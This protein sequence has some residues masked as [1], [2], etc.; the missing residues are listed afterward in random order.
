[1]TTC[2]KHDWKPH[3]DNPKKV[4]CGA[5]GFEQYKSKL[6]DKQLQE[7]AKL[8]RPTLTVEPTDLL[9]FVG[10]SYYSPASFIAEARQMGACKRVP[11][12]PRG[13]VKGVSKVFLAHEYDIGETGDDGKTVY[14]SKVFAWYTVRG[15]IYV[16]SAS[17]NIPE[18]L[19]ERGVTEWKYVEGGFSFS[20]ERGCGS[21]ATGGTYLL[22]EE[23]MD[24]VKDLAESTTMQGQIELIE[25][26]I[27]IDLKRFR[28]YK[29]VVGDNILNR[30]SE[31]TWY[32]DAWEANQRNKKAVAKFTRKLK[33]WKKERADAEEAKAEQAQLEAEGIEADRAEYEARE[34]ELAEQGEEQ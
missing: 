34:E 16:V 26:P 3:P 10:K 13:V 27:P 5:C 11:M 22:S 4:I 30:L 1:M 28:G 2:K 7:L 12:L 8:E 31:E 19:K 18:A 21:L 14:Q 15:I 29:A 17:V 24:K 33:N 32:E 9:M 20:N 6:S 25:P 23:D